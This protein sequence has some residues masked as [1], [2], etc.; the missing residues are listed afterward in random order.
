MEG[1]CTVYCQLTFGVYTKSIILGRNEKIMLPERSERSHRVHY[2]LRSVLQA[3]IA[4][5][6]GYFAVRKAFLL[7]SL[8]LKANLGKW[9]YADLQ[10]GREGEKQIREDNSFN[11]VC[12]VNDSLYWKRNIS[13][14]L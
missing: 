12:S 9:I 14:I 10:R 13:T 8:H 4:E 3:A 6:Q 1:T 7:S 2:L 5:C 11:I